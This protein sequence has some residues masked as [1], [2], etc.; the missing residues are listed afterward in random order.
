MHC[1]PQVT[2]LPDARSEYEPNGLISLRSMAFRRSASTVLLTV[3]VRCGATPWE[4]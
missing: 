1:M 4:G 2:Q 3:C